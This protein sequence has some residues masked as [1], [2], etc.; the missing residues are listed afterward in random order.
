VFLHF[1]LLAR[2]SDGNRVENIDDARLGIN[3]AIAELMVLCSCRCLCREHVLRIATVAPLLD[4]AQT[5]IDDLGSDVQR[6]QLFDA[7]GL[8]QRPCSR[9]APIKR[10]CCAASSHGSTP[11]CCPSS[12]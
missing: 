2:P 10:V 4:V 1:P 6:L 5:L 3:V 7:V 11:N 8:L 9:A 12:S